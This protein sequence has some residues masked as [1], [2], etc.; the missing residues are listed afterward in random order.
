ME[1][2]WYNTADISWIDTSKPMVA[3]SFDDGPV[4]TASSDTSIR[5]QDALSENGFH[6]TFFYWGNFINSGTEAEITR[7]YN[8]GMEIGNH[9]MSHPSLSGMSAAEIQNEIQSCA[10]ILQGLTGQ[11]NFLIRPPYLAVDTAVQE[12]A[13]APLITCSVDSA[14]WNGATTQEIID[15]M[16]AGMND[17]SLDNAIV[18]MHETYTTTAEAIEYLAPY[19]KEQGWQIVTV[20]EMFKANGKEM[21]DG[22]V[23]RNA[24]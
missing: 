22:T 7:A 3:F 20:S 4:G 5:I 24:N 19:M 9:T 23:Y 8:L 11:E 10:S 21:Y 6:A 13:G 2:Q 16:I 15:K 14:D 18:L 12:N 1:G 17:G